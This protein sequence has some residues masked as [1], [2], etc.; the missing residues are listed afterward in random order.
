MYYS[1]YIIRT[2]MAFVEV[3][4]EYEKFIIIRWNI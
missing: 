4:E 1:I 2:L 3:Y